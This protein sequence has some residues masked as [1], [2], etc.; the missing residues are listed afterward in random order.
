MKT[1]ELKTKLVDLGWRIERSEVSNCGWYAW[2]PSIDRRDWPNCTNN[3]K[4]P[5]FCIEPYEFNHTGL[6]HSS[7][8][9]SVRGGVMPG[10]WVDLKVYSVPMDE[11]LAL[12]PTATA[13]LKAAWTAAS[14]AVK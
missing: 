8:E 1:E 14:S 9:F 12:I 5:S 3:E 2:L 11:C 6:V 13:I 4:P 10:Q 7:V